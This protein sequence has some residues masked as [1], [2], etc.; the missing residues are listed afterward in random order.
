MENQSVYIEC[1]DPSTRIITKTGMRPI[2]E[3]AI[4]DEVL[5]LSGAFHKITRI[6]RN[7]YSDN[8]IKIKARGLPT[9]IATP[10]HPV[11]VKQCDS[12]KPG[13]KGATRRYGEP[14]WVK[15]EDIKH[16]DLL[17]LP[18]PVL[19]DDMALW[20]TTLLGGPRSKKLE[21]FHPDR[22]TLGMIGL[23]LSEGNIRQDERTVQFT[24]GA[25]EDH[26]ASLLI[27]WACSH[28]MG[29]HSVLN[30][31]ARTI[32]IF[33][34]ALAMWLGT[35]FGRG[36][37]NKHLPGWLML[38]PWSRITPIVEYYIRGDG[39]LWDESRSDISVTTRSQQLAEQIQLV[40]LWA[41]YAA[42][43][44]SVSDH[45]KPRYRVSVGGDSAE[46]L[47]H[48][49][50]ITLPS[51]G[52]GRSRRYNHIRISSDCVEFPVSRIETVASTGSVFNL[53]VEIDHSYCVPFVVHNCWVEKDA[54]SAVL[55]R[56]VEPYGCRL[57]VN[58]GYSSTTAMHDAF[59]RF[60]EPWEQ[61]QAVN[62]LY[63]GDHDPS[64]MDMVRDISAR[65]ETFVRGSTE[66]NENRAPFEIER[67]ALTMDQI[68]EYDPPPNPAKVKDPRAEAYIAEFGP[69]SWEVDALPPEVLNSLVEH[70]IQR[71]ID[72]DAFDASREQERKERQTLKDLADG[73]EE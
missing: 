17:A 68:E 47:A 32:Y 19:K 48:E 16:F 25:H 33:S 41:G 23:Y 38:Q 52:I 44:D 36:A 51:K 11:W 66:V 13:Y 22:S 8:L 5:T 18:R 63:L 58:R 15:A 35:Q 26:Q 1:F 56:A 55:R 6:I 27:E 10:N 39:S 7:D 3:L 72:L 37:F 40:L 21:G 60:I 65:V 12:T 9:V 24:L 61:G 2:T 29:S 57:M 49:W 31:G 62:I 70:G 34:K 4:G 14:A 73:M 46:Q 59:K 64:G 50:G 69:V 54:L 42:S 45:S 28:N 67:L 43:L 20:P 71:M 53:E 30:N